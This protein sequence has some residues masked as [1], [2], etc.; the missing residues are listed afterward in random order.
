MRQKLAKFGAFGADTPAR[1]GL[2]RHQ[3][4]KKQP[5]I[6]VFQQPASLT[7]SESRGDFPNESIIWRESSD[8][9]GGLRWFL[10][11]PLA[12]KLGLRP[13]WRVLQA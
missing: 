8:Q 12:V 7:E 10:S 9:H 6:H 13:M 5:K 3:T 1:P 4:S 2:P 11:T